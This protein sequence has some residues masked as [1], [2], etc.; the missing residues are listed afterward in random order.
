MRLSTV[1]KVSDRYDLSV[2]SAAAVA[3]AVLVDVGL[4]S[5]EDLSLVIDKNKIHRAVC[6]ARRDA[7]KDVADGSTS[8]PTEYS[9]PIE[10]QLVAYENKPTL[11]F[12]A[13]IDNLPDLP[14]NVVNE[15]STDQK[16]LYEIC[17]AVLTGFCTPE[18]ANRQA[19]KMAHSRWLTTANRLL[20]LYE[21][22]D[23]QPEPENS[24]T[25]S[26][27]GSGS[28]APPSIS[29]ILS[30]ILYGLDDGSDIDRS[31]D[32]EEDSDVLLSNKDDILR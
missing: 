19:G 29:E 20:R 25:N 15:L 5:T 32:P 21:K 8:N 24:Q 14:K 10:K 6:K 7:S 23:E 9:G 22:A 26:K 27:L 28:N 17:Q 2:R 16:Y 12:S 3:S 31:Y 13:V 4:V 18:L 11:T 30:D 1:A